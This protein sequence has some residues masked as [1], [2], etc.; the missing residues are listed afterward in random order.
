[1]NVMFSGQ[2]QAQK[3][4]NL[5]LCTFNAIGELTKDWYLPEVGGVDGENHV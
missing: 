1:M 4:I 2:S 5:S 3:T